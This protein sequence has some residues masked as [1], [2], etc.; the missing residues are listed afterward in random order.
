MAVQIFGVRKSRDTRAALRFFAERRIPTHFVDFTVRPASPGELR[1]FVQ[2]FGVT[3]LVDSN[4]K[5]YRDL[6]LGA[7]HR[8]DAWWLSYLATEPLILRMPLV[9][10]DTRLTVGL[11]TKTWISWADEH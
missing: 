7:S 11:D 3:A 5:R 4:T 9:R 8:S 1:R 6:G 10:H 2:R